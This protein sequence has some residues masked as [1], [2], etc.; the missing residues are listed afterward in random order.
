MCVCVC[1]RARVSEDLR[2]RESV[3]VNV[4]P[5]ARACAHIALPIH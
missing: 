1:A 2:V 5:R 3:C 4:G